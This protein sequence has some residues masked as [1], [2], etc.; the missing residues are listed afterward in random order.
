VHR[1]A[2][3]PADAWRDRRLAL[4]GRDLRQRRGHAMKR[5]AT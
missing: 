1:E 4:G 2:S 5:S 3:T